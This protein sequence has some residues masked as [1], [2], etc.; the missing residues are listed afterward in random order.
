MPEILFR[1][2][3]L[4]DPASGHDAVTDVAVD[5]E[6]IAAVGDAS[7]PAGST[8]IDADGLVMAP[9]LVDLH[10]HLREPG[11]E[12]KET[13]ETGTR[14]AA[15]GGFT[16]ICAMPNTDPVADNVAVIGEVRNLADK[17]GLCDVVPAGSITRGLAGEALTDIGEM[18]EAGVR[19]FTDDGRSVQSSRV[20]R[21]ALEYAKAF[22]VVICQHA[23]DEALT[24][25][26]QMHEGQY[27][28]L[29]GLA[30]YPAEAEEIVA[31]RDIA[32]ARLS[33]GR[34]HLTHVSAAQTIELIRAAMARKQPMTADVTPHHLTL[35]DADLVSYDTNLKVNPPV[36]SA[37]HRDA[38]RLALADGVLDAIATD[39][40]PHAPEEKEQEFDQAPPGTTGLETAL[41]VVLTELV[42]PGVIDL[43]SAIRR[44][45]SVPAHILGLGD[46]GGPLTPGRP[47]NLVVF[48]P[49]AE[50]V[51]GER[52]MFS[53][54]R[55]SAFAGQR[56]RGRVLHTMVRGEFT[57]RD[58]EPTR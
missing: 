32:L 4:V 55:N 58:G 27:S 29:L 19:L 14:S 38:L 56:L 50:W 28:A 3:R 30:G 40:A 16:A 41:A 21:L 11:F 35:T 43:S 25:G 48:D 10:T 49:S 31:A 20:M 22:D 51:V 46:H 24:E 37:E 23:Q 53:M 36:R 13:I 15:A 33:G 26:W 17:A 47:A 6:S 2:V 5:D 34:L 44:M 45:S 1:G 12:H 8:V 42:E 7:T 52:R 57:V 54:G 18:A 39:H 9:G